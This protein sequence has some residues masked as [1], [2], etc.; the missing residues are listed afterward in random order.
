MSFYTDKTGP[1]YRKVASVHASDLLDSTEEAPGWAQ[2][3]IAAATV[4]IEI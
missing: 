3:G 2:S 1:H 4:P